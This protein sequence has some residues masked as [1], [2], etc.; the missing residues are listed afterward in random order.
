MVRGK[1]YLNQSFGVATQAALQSGYYAH[2]TYGGIVFINYRGVDDYDAAAADGTQ[3]AIGIRPN[4]VQFFPAGAR[5]V[6][7]KAFSPMESFEFFNTIGRPLYSMMIRDE[8]R[9]FWV[10]PEVYSY[11][12]FICTRPEM[13][14]KGVVQ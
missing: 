12:I 9:D 11:P 3:R 6:F 14:M 4:E 8:R 10:R 7:Q 13:L 5:G 1:T 2:F